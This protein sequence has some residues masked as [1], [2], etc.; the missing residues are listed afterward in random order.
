[1]KE[2]TTA[3]LGKATEQRILGLIAASGIPVVSIALRD[4]VSGRQVDL[5][6]DVSLHA[7]STMKTPVMAEVFRQAAK[8]RFNLDDRIQ[9]RNQFVSIFDGS[10]YSLNPDDDSDKSLYGADDELRPIRHLVELMIQQSGN[11][12]TNLLI[13]LVGAGNVTQL[14]IELGAP[15]LAVLRGVEDGPAHRAGLNNTATARSLSTLFEC[16]G[17]GRVVNAAA[18]KEMI[19]ILAGQKH[20]EAIPPELSSSLTFAHKTGWNSDL[21]HDSGLVLSEGEPILAFGALTKGGASKQLAQELIRR[22]FLQIFEA[23]VKRA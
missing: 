12:A 16:L 20:N 11:L 22:M 8:G 21:Y 1:M 23:D 17:K 18:S 4:L 13:D 10:A 15:G 7:A 14:M 5:E 2:P 3:L 19:G 9:V 6:P